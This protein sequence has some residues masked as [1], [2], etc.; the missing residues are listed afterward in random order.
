MIASHE[1][2]VGYSKLPVIG[3]LGPFAIERNQMNLKTLIDSMQ[4]YTHEEVTRNN[5]NIFILLYCSSMYI[6]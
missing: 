5:E 6:W 1:E 2:P 3:S 4:I